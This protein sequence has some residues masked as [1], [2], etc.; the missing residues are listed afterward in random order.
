[1]LITRPSRYLKVLA[2]T[3]R[4]DNKLRK[5]KDRMP[6]TVHLTSL[7][8]AQI[9]CL[10][11]ERPQVQDSAR[12]QATL[13]EEFYNIPQY[14]QRNARIAGLPQFHILHSMHYNSI[15]QFE[16]TNAHLQL[17]S[18]FTDPSIGSTKFYKTVVQ[19]FLHVLAK[20]SSPW[21]PEH[22]SLQLLFEV[23]NSM[24][25]TLNIQEV[26]ADICRKS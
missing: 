10:I 5:F 3:L 2:R 21:N 12:R 6:I 20:N 19:L 9:S 7:E 1:M 17:I 8:S 23:H 11:F 15:L 14:L 24:Y 22:K 13:I 26:L 4:E 18:G 25:I 16:T